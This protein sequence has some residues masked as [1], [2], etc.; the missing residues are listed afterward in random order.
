MSDVP[1]EVA[2]KSPV[3]VMRTTRKTLWAVQDRGN[4]P[5]PLIFV[6]AGYGDAWVAHGLAR[7]LDERTVYCLQPS[8]RDSAM[9]AR[10]L[11]AVYVEH[12]QAA[13]QR[14]PYCLC[15]YSAGAVMA[16][17]IA[18]QLRARGE[19]VGLLALLD[20]LFA[21]YTRFEHLSYHG[22]QRVYR[23]TE[24]ILTRKPRLMQIL[25]AMFEDQGLEA[26][27]EALAGYKPEPYP[28][29][30]VYYRAR[31]TV[32]RSPM[33]VRQWKW[34]TRARFRVEVVPGGHHTFIR[35]PHVA[36]LARRLRLELQKPGPPNSP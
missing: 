14:G 25:S 18:S 10:E 12:L 1:F 33:L 27:L 16:L 13:Q 24:K 5:Q 4:D 2:V 29:E 34:L 7:A 32:G 30:I 26:H 11:A 36:E 28:G 23:I 6:M 20:P 31:W 9:T 15:G 17:E 22:L 3:A 19:A 8:A 35:P 21:R